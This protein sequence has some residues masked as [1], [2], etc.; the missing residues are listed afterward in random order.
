[1]P[2]SAALPRARPPVVAVV[3][4]TA[5]GKTGLSLDLAEALGGEVVNTD[6]MQ[7]YTGMDIGTAKLPVAQRRGIAHHLLDLLD[8]TEP[9]S[10]AEFQRW[11]RDVIADCRARGVSPVLVGGSALYTRAVLDRFEFPGTDPQVRARLEQEVAE[12]GTEAAHRRLAELD[13]AAAEKIIATNSR[14]V[15]RALEVVEITGR[16]FSASLPELRYAVEDAHQIGVEIP[17]EV[18]DERIALRV[19][20]MWEAGFVEE[21]RR[22]AERGLRAGRTANRALGYQQV[23]S[24]LDGQ[25]TEEQAVEQTTTATR[26]FARRQDSWFRKD[27]R[28]TW[29]RWDDPDRVAK[30]LAALD[31]PA[32]G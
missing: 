15:V 29:V 3:G 17:R 19:H 28:I 23:L 25:I 14:R 12:S 8:V 6:A 20:Q 7:V 26:R 5:A 9:A 2:P 31:H 13:P 21:V 1:M 24:F 30:A 16:P 4:P 10:V 32:P 22:L 18:L 27:P 11:A